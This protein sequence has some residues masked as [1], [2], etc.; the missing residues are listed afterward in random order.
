[1]LYIFLFAILFSFIIG[2]AVFAIIEA[3]QHNK[4]N[5][6]IIVGDCKNTRWG[7]CPDKIVP[8][9]DQMGTNCILNGNF[10]S[11]KPK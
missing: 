6:K 7:C 11:Q 3:I 1:M 4:Q 9:Y 8:K 5:N 10:P 2:L